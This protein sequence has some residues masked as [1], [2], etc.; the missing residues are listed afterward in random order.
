MNATEY[1]EYLLSEYAYTNALVIGAG[2]EGDRPNTVYHNSEN[3]EDFSDWKDRYKLRKKKLP[4]DFSDLNDLKNEK[5]FDLVIASRV[6]EHIPVRNVDYFIYNIYEVMKL[7]GILV[8]V[9]PDMPAVARALE[10]ECNQIHFDHFGFMRLNFELLSEGPHVF[11]RHAFWTSERSMEIFMG[12]EDLFTH[13]KT[14][15]ISIDSTVTPPLLEMVYKR[16]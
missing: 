5:L 13:Q 16:L 1:T 10:E 4:E 14:N 11:D 9:V 3:G 6:L 2:Y 8:C 12:Q 7:G 15:R